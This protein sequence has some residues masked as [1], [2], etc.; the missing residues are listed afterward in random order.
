MV[1]SQ[2]KVGQ[3][4]HDQTTLS[5]FVIALPLVACG[6]AKNFSHLHCEWMD[7][8]T[9]K[10]ENYCY[11]NTG[12]VCNNYWPVDAQYCAWLVFGSQDELVIQKFTA[13]L[14]GSA[15][16]EW[17]AVVC[18]AEGPEVETEL[19]PPNPAQ[20]GNTCNANNNG[21]GGGGGGSGTPTTSDGSAGT[22]G[23]TGDATGS[24]GDTT[25]GP[26]DM[27]TYLCSK[28]AA[29]QCADL[30]PDN[31]FGI[32]QNDPYTDPNDPLSSLWDEC[33]SAVNP[34]PPKH[35]SKCVDA[36]N[37]GDALTQCQDRCG[38]FKTAMADLCKAP[39]CEILRDVDCLLNG[40]YLAADGMVVVGD[41]MGEQPVLLEGEP[42]WECD[43]PPLQPLL[44]DP[45]S[46][47]A[48]EGT[49]VMITPEGVSVGM[50]G[51][52]G[53]LSYSLSSCDAVTCTITIDALVST[54]VHTEGG[55]TDAAGSG[56]VY[57]LDGTGF[58]SSAPFS[59]TW[60][61]ER[62][63]IAF[64]TATVSLDFWAGSAVVDGVGVAE[65]AGPYPAEI[66][67][68]VGSLRSTQGP[69]TLNLNY[70]MPMS[71]TVSLSLR[72]L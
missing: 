26:G 21:G 11:D 63:T 61:K 1:P 32:S 59:G 24:T 60:Y 6:E 5:L 45:G 29:H 9:L 7:G 38:E 18:D 66:D 46:L 28:Q 54:T 22:S 55:Y 23:S 13:S 50:S 10:S 40:T 49:G 62:G 16:H 37:S 3:Y 51:L 8:E 65:N 64:P 31:A 35:K 52:R 36:L 39:D 30:F 34:N 41:P 25:G 71:G 72:T 44:V 15:S 27:K 68:V 20:P 56:G 33:W 53:Y 67:Q 43:G 42:S 69:L 48:F 4:V 12:N 2:P 58:W 14:D 19:F 17:T 57:I 70:E 47:H